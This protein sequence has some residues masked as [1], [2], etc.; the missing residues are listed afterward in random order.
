[1]T[2]TN[3][4]NVESEEAV[5]KGRRRKAQ[6]REEFRATMGIWEGFFIFLLL[7]FQRRVASVAV[8]VKKLMIQSN[9]TEGPG[10]RREGRE[11]G[12]DEGDG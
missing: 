9:V 10:G 11:G 3:D 1:M 7:H 8:A 4:C 2:D 12:R 5:R 6:G